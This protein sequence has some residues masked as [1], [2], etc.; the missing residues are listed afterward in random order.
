MSFLVSS[1]PLELLDILA[2]IFLQPNQ[3]ICL[4]LSETLDIF[5]TKLIAT[6]CPHAVV[7]RLLA[8]YRT[9]VFHPQLVHVHS[10]VLQEVALIIHLT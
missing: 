10:H 4:A 3:I 5:Q 6:L 9:Q 8:H 1:C 7:R 2:D